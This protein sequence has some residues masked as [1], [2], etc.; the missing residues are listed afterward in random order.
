MT[1][2]EKIGVFFVVDFNGS[3][4]KAGMTKK[5]YHRA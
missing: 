3:P 2:G 5:L 1:D 4:L